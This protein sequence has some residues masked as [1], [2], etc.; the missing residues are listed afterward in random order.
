MSIRMYS[1]R[2]GAT[3]IG[4]GNDMVLMGVTLPS[5]STI[6][7]I[8][9]EICMQSAA[10]NGFAKGM[11]YAC[12][13]WILPLVD[14]DAATSFQTL[15][16]TLVPKD[17]DTD[18]LDLDTGAVDSTPFFEPGEI[19]PGM[20]FNVGLQPERIF[21]RQRM[22]TGIRDGMFPDFDASIAWQTDRF[23]LRIK[24][25]YYIEQPSVMLV[26]I[27]APSMDDVTTTIEAALTEN[28]LPRIKYVQAVMEQALIK[29]LGLIE[30][31]A[32]T[33]YEEAIDLLQKHLEPDVYQS[34]GGMWSAAS[35]QSW[36]RM[37]VDHSVVGEM[38][39]FSL[40]SGR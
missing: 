31:G 27:A 23:D 29:M 34:Q 17:T 1:R 5:E 36:G 9:G 13:A 7:G 28:E 26:G 21:A 2:F 32:E 11:F 18:T 37:V 39:N 25:N 10:A 20:L 30:S 24:K 3:T 16:D 8:N 15:W 38:A 4:A 14:P 6:N 40:S 22:M 35:W 12:E 33:P 19:E